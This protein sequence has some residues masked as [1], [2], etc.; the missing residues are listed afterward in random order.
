M[1]R[2]VDNPLPR[3]GRKIVNLQVEGL[4]VQQ[5]PDRG[6]GG[7]KKAE[8]T[9]LGNHLRFKYSGKRT[10]SNPKMAGERRERATT[11]RE[12]KN[13]RGP[14]QKKPLNR[15]QKQKMTLQNET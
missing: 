11:A 10:T 8:L 15:L 5:K 2:G 3:P 7:T 4:E 9:W 13:Q 1:V 12:G 14:G 6:G